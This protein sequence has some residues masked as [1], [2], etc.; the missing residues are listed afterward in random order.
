M[1]PGNGLREPLVV[2]RQASEARRPGEAALHYPPA[3]QEHE[4]LL[5][6]GVLDHLQSDAARFRRF[7]RL[8]ARVALVHI[9]QL[10]A[11]ARG[12]LH[13]PRRSSTCARSCSAAG[14]TR[15]ASRYPRVS[16]AACIL[17]PFL[18]FAPS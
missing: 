18:R 11:L 2:A 13:G 5:G 9:R 10:D 3:L 1:K 16:T 15:R 12:L 7:C 4:A 8:L 17:E 6:A 14:V